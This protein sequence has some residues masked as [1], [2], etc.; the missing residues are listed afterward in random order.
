MGIPHLFFLADHDRS[1]IS[2]IPD[3]VG[4]V[5][6]RVH[7]TESQTTLLVSFDT[8]AWKRLV[9]VVESAAWEREEME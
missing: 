3:E 5:D 7:D 9:E 6:L 4:R 2:V 1:E 8:A